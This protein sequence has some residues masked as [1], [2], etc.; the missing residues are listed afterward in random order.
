MYKPLLALFGRFSSLLGARVAGAICMFAVNLLV[1]RVFGLEV[2][3][4]FALYLAGTGLLAVFLSAGFNSVIVFFAAEY[5]ARKQPGLIKGFLKASGWHVAAGTAL[6]CLV[7]AIGL[8]AAGGQLPDYAAHL[9]V[10]TVLSAIAL[11]GVLLNGGLMVALKHQFRGLAPETLVRPVLLLA[12]VLILIVAAPQAGLNAVLWLAT[13]A[14]W[15]GLVVSLIWS[16]RLLQ[17]ILQAKADTEN[18]RWRRAAYPWIPVSLL[19][20]YL[21][22]LMIL[23]AGLFAGA[24]EVAILHICFRFRV[25]SGFGMRAIYALLIPELAELKTQGK[26]AKLR[27]RLAQANWAALAY[28]STVLLFFAVA[29]AQLLSLF[30]RDAGEGHLILLIICLTLP[31]RAVFGPAPAILALNDQYMVSA[32]V[33]IAGCMA[34]MVLAVALYPPF[35]VAGYAIGYTMANLAVS[36]GLWKVVQQQTGMNCSVFQRVDIREITAGRVRGHQET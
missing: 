34:G 20:D 4:V 9:A 29:G 13:G 21:I 27:L 36:A 7:L 3:G 14:M 32:V 33:M 5:A 1:A 19:W 23:A 8:P 15:A 28:A 25:L 24:E 31:V 26:Y 35:Q 6:V 18:G 11:S 10:Q 12:A 22:D 17:P 16:R 2:L 30:G